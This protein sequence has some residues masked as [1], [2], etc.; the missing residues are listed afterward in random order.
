MANTIK[1]RVNPESMAMAED[2]MNIIGLDPKTTRVT[3]YSNCA[4]QD[5]LEFSLYADFL[6]EGLPPEVAKEQAADLAPIMWA[7]K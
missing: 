4:S 6:K 7:K 3:D 5:D 1:P 2:V